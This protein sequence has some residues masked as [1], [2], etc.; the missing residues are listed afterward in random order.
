MTAL[1]DKTLIDVAACIRDG[2]VSSEDVTR[3]CLARVDRVD[4]LINAFTKVKA[5]RALQQ[6]RDAD[7]ARRAGAP[8]PLL[9]GVPL[10]HKDMFYRAGEESA[11]GSLI[12]Q[13]W[14]ASTTADVLKRLD[15]AGAVTLGRLNMSEFA[16]GPIGLNAHFGPTRNPWATDHVSGG[17]SSGPAAAV[18]ARLS[19]GAL[20][21]DTGASIRVPAAACGIV[22]LKPSYG[23]ISTAGTMPLSGSLDVVG[24]LAR[25]VADVALLTGIIATPADD[26]L[27]T[28]IHHAFFEA[29]RGH[30]EQDRSVR[31]GVSRDYFR[32]GL[33]PEIESNVDENIRIFRDLGYRVH[34]VDTSVFAEAA[35]LYSTI[36]GTEASLL[37]ASTL[38]ER[39]RDYSPQV[40]ARLNMGRQ[41]PLELYREAVGKRTHLLVRVMSEVFRDIDVLVAPVISRAVPTITEIDVGDGAGM[42]SVVGAFLRLT[43]PVNVLGL[44]ALSVPSGFASNGLP[45]G[46]QLIGAPWSDPVLLRLGRVH[47]RAALW[48]SHGPSIS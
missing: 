32:N 1:T 3:A 22:G 48:T 12:R 36:F 38:D 14:E 29:A 9:H 43:S 6:A 5:E 4:P 26:R 8:L 31:I 2:S 33:T 34:P 21:S 24:P 39:A 10:A 35:A 11:C 17:S 27:S 44:P 15:A 46:I 30:P 16:I 42:L 45:M 23:W 25:T 40:R 37:H 28:P 47:E 20:G 18:A 7:L 19:F 13:G 41:V